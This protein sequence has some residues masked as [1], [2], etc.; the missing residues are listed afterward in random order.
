MDTF[1]SLLPSG[2]HSEDPYSMKKRSM[3]EITN[4]EV[5]RLWEVDELTQRVGVDREGDTRIES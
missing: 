2:H 3:P 4:L 1:L 5:F